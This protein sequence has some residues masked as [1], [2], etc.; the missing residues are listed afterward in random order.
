MI[1]CW[2]SSF[3]TYTYMLVMTEYQPAFMP[4]EAISTV[5]CLKHNGAHVN[6]FFEAGMF[7]MKFFIG[8]SSYCSSACMC[9]IYV[10]WLELE[11]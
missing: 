4:E 1:D 11:V 7:S 8:L 6:C 3:S 10:F 2:N 5:V 9:N